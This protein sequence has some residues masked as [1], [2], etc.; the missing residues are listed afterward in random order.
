MTL[1]VDF[2]GSIELARTAGIGASRPFLCVLAK[3]P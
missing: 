1:Q 3:V 2:R